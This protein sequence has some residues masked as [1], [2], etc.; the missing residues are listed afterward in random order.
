[1]AK[2]K[3]E[4]RPQLPRCKI[5][6]PRNPRRFHFGVMLTSTTVST[7]KGNCVQNFE[8]GAITLAYK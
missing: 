3:D 1:M 6:D 5:Q 8:K 4:D 7:D 2:K